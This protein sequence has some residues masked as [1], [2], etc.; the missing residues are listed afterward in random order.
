MKLLFII[1]T[2]RC[3][4][5][6]IHELVALN[7]QAGF[8]SN[9]DDRLSFMNSYGRWNN[10]VFYSMKGRLTQKGQVRFAPSEAYHLIAKQVSPIYE[11]S[12]RDLTAEDVTP[13]LRQRFTDFF[14]SR[15]EA[16]Q[17]IVFLHK[18]TG[19]SR[20][21][22]FA[23]IFP[24]AKFV[25]IVRDGRAVANSWLQMPWWGGY[26]GPEKWL[27]GALSSDDQALW[28]A[29]GYGYPVLA[30]LAWKKLMTG[31]IDAEKRMD[32]SQYMTCR[33][34]DFIDNPED[35]LK[36]ITSWGGLPDAGY[37]N[38]AF[39][40]SRVNRN[41][42]QAFREDLTPQQLTDIEA[43]IGHLLERYHYE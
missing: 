5:S 33:Y 17:K 3:G 21:R 35:V 36:L 26:Q 40:A 41:R 42:R 2:G 16:Q 15:F 28:E 18:Y 25:H 4:S 37:V 20:I 23:E 19:W 11:N 13:W 12:C 29:K 27:W 31:F 24:E 30:A 14:Q 43:C 8:I 1:G 34:E 9:L 10:R 22:F 6:L 39:L 7:Q 32:T 38:N